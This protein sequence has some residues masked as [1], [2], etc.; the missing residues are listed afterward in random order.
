MLKDR[1]ITVKCFHP[2]PTN[3]HLQKNALELENHG[4][5]NASIF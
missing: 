4:W 1:S 5:N 2:G 3:T